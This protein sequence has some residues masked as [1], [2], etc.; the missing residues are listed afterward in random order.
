MNS[1]T[2]INLSKKLSSLTNLIL[3][4]IQTFNFFWVSGDTYDDIHYYN[5]S[6]FESLKSDSNLFCF[7]IDFAS[8]SRTTIINIYIDIINKLLIQ[9][10]T[11]S[12]DDYLSLKKKLT[13][14][15]DST[16]YFKLFI[17]DNLQKI[18]LSYNVVYEDYKYEHQNFNSYLSNIFKCISAYY[19][20]CLIIE[21]GH[22]L[23]RHVITL[24]SSFLLA[25]PSLTIVFT[26]PNDNLRY[27]SS[28]NDFFSL[29]KLN[30]YITKFM[31][32]PTLI[33]H[34][35]LP[36]LKNIS[37]LSHQLP[38]IDVL[39]CASLIIK[40]SSRSIFLA[41]YFINNIPFLNSD[42][43][44]SHESLTL[45]QLIETLFNKLTDATKQCMLLAALEDS[46]FNLYEIC[47]YYQHDYDSVKIEALN[48]QFIIPEISL[49][50]I[51]IV[52]DDYF[53]FSTIGISSIILDLIDTDHLTQ[54]HQDHISYS[55][56]SKK[57]ISY[58]SVS[59]IMNLSHN[60][61]LPKTISKDFFSQLILEA[62]SS[63]HLEHYH[64][65]YD[66][67]SLILK[68]FK[69]KFIHSQAFHFDLAYHH[70]LCKLDSQNTDITKDWDYCFSVSTNNTERAL[71]SLFKM[72]WLHKEQFSFDHI[73]SE[74]R[75]SLKSLSISLGVIPKYQSLISIMLMMEYFKL[76]YIK[77][78]KR[79][80][81]PTKNPASNHDLLIIG[82]L[83]NMLLL[84]APSHL[85]E[86]ITMIKARVLEQSTITITRIN[87]ITLI[88]ILRQ[89]NIDKLD[90]QF[91][92]VRSPSFSHDITYVFSI[93]NLLKSLFYFPL[94]KGLSK[95]T[96][97]ISQT[98]SSTPPTDYH[99]W[100][101]FIN[102]QVYFQCFNGISIETIKKSY[103][104][105]IFFFLNNCHIPSSSIILD[106]ISFHNSILDSFAQN[107]TFDVTNFLLK[108]KA[109]FHNNDIIEQILKLLVVFL[110]FFK[111]DYKSA[112]SLCRGLENKIT[113]Y[114]TGIFYP[115]FCF[116][117]SLSL[118]FDY[119]Y[120][121]T[122][123]SDS[124]P[125]LN[126]HIDVFSHLTNQKLDH[127]K[128]YKLILESIKHSYY[129]NSSGHRLILEAIELSV[130]HQQPLVKL[131]AHEIAAIFYQ[132]LHDHD[133]IKKHIDSCMMGYDQIGYAYKYSSLAK[134]YYAYCTSA[135][136][137][138]DS[139]DNIVFLLKNKKNPHYIVD[140]ELS[141]MFQFIFR[142][143]DFH[144][145]YFFKTQDQDLVLNYRFSSKNASLDKCQLSIESL[146]KFI[147]T[148]CYHVTYT[149]II[150]HEYSIQ[151][152]H[153]FSNESHIIDEDIHSIIAIPLLTPSQSV[154]G[155]LYFENK[156]PNK[157]FTKSQI[158][159]LYN[160]VNLFELIIHNNTLIQQPSSD[161]L[162][163]DLSNTDSSSF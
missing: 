137:S 81:P 23:E 99:Y 58:V 143:L 15:C 128:S 153:P 10:R 136:D 159:N 46:P 53:Q 132:E 127:F 155:I 100:L 21:N 117:Y 5:I 71:L 48:S 96:H 31:S 95:S 97:N 54:I 151:N 13:A 90:E 122:H 28:L 14:L 160:Y 80:M 130:T 108:N 75:G 47:S 22:L 133:G 77:L 51:A 37:N 12:P 69:K 106:H 140:I 109:L 42:F 144:T 142:Y 18:Q 91:N 126:K 26:F 107:T 16:N 29:L 121:A 110:C 88:T 61:T 105:H 24:L 119:K 70:L 87:F 35:I 98:L 36:V 79:I 124:L 149:K 55:I 56:L 11:L 92:A 86:L 8:K 32:F 154:F 4:P 131:I 134:Q 158:K 33:Y 150:L 145:G 62:Y 138:D 25:K 103:D 73:I 162:S 78:I 152:N 27:Y 40:K 141:Y 101:A 113:D 41:T 111:H 102:F 9:N 118:Y 104:L 59:F 114:F 20:I 94:K 66:F 89:G 3:K 93:N 2:T 146:P 19:P 49:S 63:I 123:S 60:Y 84:T 135:N 156:D 120:S 147:K 50:N 57:S 74:A 6:L 44:Q 72:K 82:Q 30:N 65:G 67:F 38:H 76:F 64:I 85:I 157:H 1:L 161:S 129:N 17:N 7:Y 148:Q 125:L 34:D 112:I 39:H 163:F 115:L 43:I 116:Y 68:Y 52:R 83:L 45:H 139:S